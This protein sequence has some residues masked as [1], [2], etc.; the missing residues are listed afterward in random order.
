MAMALL[1][2]VFVDPITAVAAGVL[3]AALAYIKQFADQ[4]LKQFSGEDMSTLVITGEEDE[5]LKKVQG[6]VTIFDFGGP[7]SFGA[8][9][10]VRNTLV[11]LNSLRQLPVDIRYNTPVEALRVAVD[12]ILS[13]R[14]SSQSKTS[15]PHAA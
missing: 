14:G 12:L 9:A 1:M 15:E 6:E 13:E 10:D 11:S 8:A 3:L 4:Q 5:L 7:L 2:T